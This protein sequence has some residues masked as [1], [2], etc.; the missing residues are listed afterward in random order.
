MGKKKDK[1]FKIV[2][3]ESTKALTGTMILR[4]KHTDVHYLYVAAG[5]GGGLTALLDENG[6]PITRSEEKI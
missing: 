2:L 6:K 5:Y 1:R 4:D 3:N